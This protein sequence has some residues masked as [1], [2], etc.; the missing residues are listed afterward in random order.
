MLVF[1]TSNNPHKPLA[2]FAIAL[3]ILLS[4]APPA[5]AGAASVGLDEPLYN[6]A[7]ITDTQTPECEWITLLTSRLRSEK[8]KII[9][10]TGDTRFEWANR[11]AWKDVTDLM[12]LETPP[13]EFHL[14]P[15]NH[16]LVNGLLKH[17][18]RRAAVNG[19]YRLDTGLTV[20]NAGYYH[21]RLPEDACGPL[22]PLWNPAVLEHPAWQPAADEKPAGSQQPDMPY[23]YTFKRGGLRFIVC[24]PFYTAS[25]R[26][27]IQA[28]LAEP[29]DSS[30]SI[31]LHHKHEPD[32]LAKYF[33]GLEGRH[34]V[35]LVLSGDHHQYCYEQRD[36][37]TYVTAAGIYHGHHGDCDAMILRVYSD[38]L[39]LDR[40]VVPAGLPMNPISGPE[41]IWTCPGRFTPY[42]RPQFPPRPPCPPA[43]SDTLTTIGP[44]LIINGDFENGIWYERF[45][46][47]SPS[48]WYQW[49]TRGG[50]VPEHAVGK[51]LPHSGAEYVRLHMWA[52]AWRAGI[53]QNVRGVDPCHMYKMT[54]YGFFQPEAAPEPK[55][56]IGID[57]HG[58]LARQFSVD[59]S[60]H[61]AP[62]YDEGV[63]DDPKTEQ[64]DGP[65]FD[66]ATVWSR[67]H[68]YYEWGKFEVTAEAVSDTITAVLDCAPK[69]RPAA[70]P[71]YEMNWDSVALYEVPWPAR[72]LVPDELP[73]ASDPGFTKI[74]VNVRRDLGTAGVSWKTQ[75]PSGASQVLYRFLAEPN[76]PAANELAASS[77][78]RY[79]FQ[80][81]VIYE[82]SA[83]FHRAEIDHPQIRSAA[84]I[85]LVALSRCV[86]D[87][88]CVTLASA[89]LTIRLEKVVPIT[90]ADAAENWNDNIVAGASLTHAPR[91]PAGVLFDMQFADA[92]PWCYPIL[93]LRPE[94]IP[95]AS[96]RAL[97]LTVELL[98]GR[99]TVRVQFL[100]ET[101]TQYVADTNYD[102][103]K[104]GPQR[105]RASLSAVIRRPTSP[106]DANARLD[107][108]RIRR[109][110]VGINS[111]RN[112]R[113]RMAVSDLAWVK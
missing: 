20:R 99:G 56:R 86:R 59:V 48:Y 32:D 30:V 44:N 64:F 54:A 2:R 29:D 26:Q 46:G 45:R 75:T 69:Q 15:G 107:P 103:A 65:G 22:W 38:H 67:Y 8:P 70:E 27:W 76:P 87:N 31:V 50:H 100:E 112:S 104:K 51:R 61:P 106:P 92:D 91:P 110:M 94:E 25:Q 113:V 41:T 52:Y 16:D 42:E 98:E 89:P 4:A 17:H 10:H 1:P 39:R 88:R 101:G 80:T 83:A 53:L 49:F 55:A 72:R 96:F 24:D 5:P 111:R 68:D 37:I 95:D 66:D 60:K 79:P 73:L 58:T 35:R 78:A 33:D 82:K 11:C 21:N 47:W 7:W 105:V 93:R 77:S 3:I 71:I 63:G 19:I 109:I 40:F 23:H 6:V 14:A 18:L 97:E 9:I 34:N 84:A 85:E 28:L 74:V 13:V 57:P 81:P 108:D 12:L 102:L 62:K 36:P 43:P 90:S